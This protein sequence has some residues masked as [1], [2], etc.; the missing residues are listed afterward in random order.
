MRPER[1][2]AGGVAHTPG[3]RWYAVNTRLHSEQ[4]AARHL[5]LQRFE[6][7]VPMRLR[8]IKHARRFTTTKSAYF[9]RYLFV[10]F[11]VERDQWRSVNGTVGV[12][13]L[14]M[15]GMKPLPVPHGVVE[16]LISTTDSSG[17]LHPSALVPGHKVRVLAGVFLDQL[18]ILDRV[19]GADA[20]RILL[21]I[22]NRQV[23]VRIGRDQIL[24]L[25]QSAN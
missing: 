14:V 24:V 18:G 20:V 6:T 19:D 15:G 21:E 3:A 9:S 13:S 10:S 17:V 11:D 16:T 8:T 25:Q 2:H 5:K 23:P 7:F 1:M 22:M 12:V 4:V